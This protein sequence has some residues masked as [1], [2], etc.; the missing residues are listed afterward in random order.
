M[1]LTYFINSSFHIC[2]KTYS[3]IH[4]QTYVMKRMNLWSNVPV[5]LTWQIIVVYVFLRWCKLY[6]NT[7]FNHIIDSAS[8]KSENIN[9]TFVIYIYGCQPDEFHSFSD[10][11]QQRPPYSMFFAFIFVVFCVCVFFLEIKLILMIMMILYQ[12]VVLIRSF[13][14]IYM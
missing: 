6:H 14:I 7:K 2:H 4:Y 5:I 13:A 9:S 12:F 8:W 1:I 11:H 10:D 3:N